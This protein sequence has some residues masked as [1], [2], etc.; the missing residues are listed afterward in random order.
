MGIVPQTHSHTTFHKAKTR[1]LQ[2]SVPLSLT[3]MS[4]RLACCLSFS[5][6]NTV[7][8]THLYVLLQ[9]ITMF[10]V[11]DLNAIHLFTR[12]HSRKLPEIY[13]SIKS[14]L[15]D[16]IFELVMVY[17]FIQLAHVS[18][19][20]IISSIPQAHTFILHFLG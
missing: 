18:M 4:F 6:A 3:C 19:C 2:L 8:I 20:N 7:I 17:W 10:T 13:L 14:S 1:L 5:L 11:L 16:F 15:N 12:I 9:S